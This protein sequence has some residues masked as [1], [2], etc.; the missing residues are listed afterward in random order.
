MKLEIPLRLLEANNSNNSNVHPDPAPSNIRPDLAPSSALAAARQ[1]PPPPAAAAAAAADEPEDMAVEETNYDDLEVEDASKFSDD[2]TDLSEKEETEIAEC[3]QDHYYRDV[4][5]E[6]LHTHTDTWKNAL[7]RLHYSNFPSIH[8]SK[9]AAMEFLDHIHTH[10]PNYFQVISQHR[11]AFFFAVKIL[12]TSPPQ[13]PSRI[14]I[15]AD[16]IKTA[17][18]EWL[19][20]FID[21]YPNPNQDYG[22]ECL[23]SY[24]EVGDDGNIG[25]LEQA[26]ASVGALTNLVR[27][28]PFKNS[29]DNTGYDTKG[30]L[31][32]HLIIIFEAYY[33]KD[34]TEE[35]ENDIGKMMA[36]IFS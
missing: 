1:P 25:T 26:R 18:T 22:I 6:Y 16:M 12:Q 36:L 9:I 8:P 27:R 19:M 20:W 35:L 34:C 33:A 10:R 5:E 28:W 23:L 14:R 32:G 13:G 29:L 31:K 2:F 17:K 30:R 24:L 7:T 11:C 21:P 15:V 4:Q 3:F